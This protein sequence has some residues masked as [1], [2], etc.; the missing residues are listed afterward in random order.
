MSRSA[1]AS[2]VARRHL[3]GTVNVDEHG[4]ILEGEGV[5]YYDEF[6]KELAAGLKGY[7]W[8][9]TKK[10]PYRHPYAYMGL[11][12]KH[13]GG[14]SFQA[15]VQ[16]GPSADGHGQFEI[17]FLMGK[18]KLWRDIKDWRWE[19]AYG[20]GPK[21]AKDLGER[22]EDYE[23]PKPKYKG[24]SKG[25]YEITGR[26]ALVIIRGFIWG[27]VDERVDLVK[28]ATRNLVKSSAVAKMAKRGQLKDSEENPVEFKDLKARV[29]LRKSYQQ[30]NRGS[31]LTVIE[32]DVAW[33]PD[34]YIIRSYRDRTTLR[35]L[36]EQELEQVG[37]KFSKAG[38]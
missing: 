28:K 19:G 10:D 23:P 26:G 2:R 6:V 16:V 8:K 21:L 33:K 17:R 31:Y 5:Y 24:G 15:H 9:L 13:S 18:T 25:S 3:A 12:F 20:D 37:F 32:I 22:Y 4:H 1:S 34:P 11:W 29:K 36:W 27:E 30:N 14:A 38:W 35:R 7:G